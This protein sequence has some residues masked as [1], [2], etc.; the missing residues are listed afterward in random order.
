MLHIHRAER[1]DQLADGLAAQLRDPLADPFA[2]E[3]ISVPSKGV[4]RWLAQRLSHLLG[5]DRPGAGVCANMV[6]PPVSTMVEQAV[7]AAGA[8]EAD[9]W[10]PNRLVWVL[11]D[12]IDH[13]ATEPWCAA[14]GAYLGMLDG[15]PIRNGRRYATARHVAALF[16]SYG[17]QRPDLLTCWSAGEDADGVG[18]VLPAD[19]RWQAELWRRLRKQMPLPSPAERLPEVCQVLRE[20]PDRCPLPQRLS[21][22]GPTRLPAA[23][24]AVL[25]ALA[26]QREVH[27]WLPHPSPVLWERLRPYAKAAALPARAADPT[28]D[29]PRHPLLASLGRDTRELQLVLGS[30]PA[31]R[32]GQPL[33]RPDTLLGRIQQAVARDEPPDDPPPLD[34]ADR[35]VQV[36]ACHGAA[37]QVEV[38]REV[39]LG[40]LTAHPD[41]EPRDVLVMCPDIETF[42]PLISATFGLGDDSTHPG[43]G[44]RVRLADRALDRVNPLLGVV[45]ELLDLAD[46]RVTAAQVLDFAAS[47]PVRRRFRLADDDLERMRDLVVDAGVRWGLDG[48]HRARFQLG[49]IRP[50]TWA[51]GLD[52]IVLGVAMSE[53]DLCWL[54]LALPLDDVDSGDVEL[55]GRLAE[56]VDRLAGT[57]AGLS[58]QRPL[59]EWLDVIVAGVEALTAIPDADA[60]QGE[61]LRAEL[62]EVAAVAGTAPLSLPDLRS[63]V[64]ERL[65]GRPTRANFRTG[66]LTMCTM[67]PMRSVPHRVVCVLGLDDGVFPRSP[68]VDGDDVLTRNP[69]VGERDVRGEDRQLLLDAVMC[70]TDH[71]VLL[72]AGADERTNARRPPA[73]PLGELLD[74]IDRSV[75]STDGRPGHEQVLVRHPLQPFAARNFTPRA[76]GVPGPFSHDR[77]ALAGAQAAAGPQQAPPPFLS[78]PLPP[79]GDNAVVPLIELTRFLDHP[80]RAFLRRRLTVSF[81]SADEDPADGLPVELDGLATWAVGD[82]LLRARLAGADSERCVQAEWRRGAVPPGALGRRLLTDLAA[83]VERLVTAA[84]P[85]RVGEPEALDVLAELPGGRTVAGTVSGVHDHTIVSVVYSNLGPKHRLRAWVSLL[86]LAASRPDHAWRAVTIGRGYRGLSRSTLGPVGP[87]DAT[88]LLAALV[89]LSDEGQCQPLPLALKTSHAYAQC[90][91]KGSP[92]QDAL[93]KARL[94]WASFSGGGENDDPGHTLVW[95]DAAPLDALLATPATGDGTAEPTQFGALAMRLWEPLLAAEELKQL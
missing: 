90:R 64:G 75:R 69:R 84:E 27:L 36:H 47:P 57:L 77:A 33:A 56:L 63:L 44:L 43:H 51:A 53:E 29:L 17:Q 93:A 32:P 28:R 39:I 66:D 8:V 22:F 21:I 50:N 88:T 41:L 10:N 49:A 82:R 18:G 52:R 24:L 48:D 3:V 86:A 30:D 94:Q 2:A 72:Y 6:F 15:D 73:V 26:A 12:L 70:A 81:F 95:G 7:A 71:L 25:T 13:C 60:W 58:G 79:A 4:E 11:L 40:L 31:D 55:V 14:L 20:H 78:G 1:A 92:A 46:S 54:D 83:Q 80:V 5:T 35:S 61:Q 89:D 42:A 45:T 37:R 38:L 76:L 34:P 62:A 67:V 91:R 68:G 59:P 16:D 9:P 65:G 74:T 23:H 85:Y 87:K 19:L